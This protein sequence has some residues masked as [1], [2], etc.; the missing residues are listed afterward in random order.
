MLQS[1]RVGELISPVAQVKDRGNGHKRRRKAPPNATEAALLAYALVHGRLTVAQAC[2]LAGANSAYVSLINEMGA[3]EREALARGDFSLA[4]IAS[5]KRDSCGNRRNGRQ[6]SLAEHIAR[7][8]PRELIEAA[9]IVGLDVVWDGMIS[10]VLDAERAKTL[11][12]I[13]QAEQ[14]AAN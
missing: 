4:Q 7:S 1:P 8:T 11:A 12:A 13:R 2:R 10:P 5:A 9:R 3:T 14:V 6:E